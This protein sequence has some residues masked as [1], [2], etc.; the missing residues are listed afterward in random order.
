MKYGIIFRSNLCN[1]KNI[2]T[3]QKIVRIMVCVKPGN[4]CR[5]LRK[6]LE[7]VTLPCKYIFSVM[8]FIVNNQEHFQTGTD[9]H[10]VNTRNRLVLHR[11]AA[12]LSCFRKVLTILASTFS[13]IYHVV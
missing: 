3:L 10:S 5:S 11:P 1:S 12:K 13:T 7:I 2:F 8:I 6:R 4:S 9:L